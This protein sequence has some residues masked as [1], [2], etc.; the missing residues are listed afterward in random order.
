[1]SA[2]LPSVATSAF[3][4]VGLASS[5]SVGRALA[6]VAEPLFVVSAVLLVGGALACSRLAA[7]LALVGSILAFVDMFVITKATTMAQM[8]VG[9]SSPTGKALFAVGAVLI[10]AS[11]ATTVIRRRHR[12]CKPVLAVFAR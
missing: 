12:R 1:M 2:V 7:A 6:D 4:A 3:V 5:T 9:S 10:V 11:F 8:G